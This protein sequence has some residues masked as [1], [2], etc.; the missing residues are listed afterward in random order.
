MFYNLDNPPPDPRRNLN[1]D[2]IA[3]REE[4]IVVLHNI[5]HPLMHIKVQNSIYWTIEGCFL[6]KLGNKILQLKEYSL[7]KAITILW[8]EIAEL[9]TTVGEFQGDSPMSIFYLQFSKE[10]LPNLHQSQAN[11]CPH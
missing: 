3:Y 10:K 1:L 5:S 8:V 9:I 11:I 7:K 4:K 6:L 2:N